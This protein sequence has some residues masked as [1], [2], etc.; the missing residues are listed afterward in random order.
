MKKS[1]NIRLALGCMALLVLT[2][3]ATGEEKESKPVN[4]IPFAELDAEALADWDLEEAPETVE[5]PETTLD[6]D[7]DAAVGDKVP[8]IMTE[9]QAKELVDVNYFCLTEL[10][11]YGQ[12][13]GEYLS[14]TEGGVAKVCDERF[15]TYGD[16]KTFLYKYYSSYVAAE[17]L[18]HAY[19]KEPMYYEE[20]D[21]FYMRLADTTPSYVSEEK[22]IPSFWTDYTITEIK[23]SGNGCEIRVVPVCEEELE[24]TTTYIMRATYLNGGWK[25]EDMGWFLRLEEL[26]VEEEEYT[27]HIRE[28][29]NKEIHPEKWHFADGW[30]LEIYKDGELFQIIEQT[31]E[32]SEPDIDRKIWYDDVNFD[33]KKD[34]LLFWFYTGA[35]SAQVYQ[36][37]LATEDGFE[38]C[39]S[40]DMSNPRIDADNRQII[41]S[42]R[43]GAGY[44]ELTYYQYEGNEFVLKKREEYEWDLDKKEYTVTTFTF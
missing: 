37:Y 27:F 26:T 2:G 20:N 6:V 38:L 35:Q 19:Q 10:F 40:F 43:G 28:I 8:V 16:L 5:A 13:E 1:R 17:M 25:L 18:N 41:G 32:L 23:Q 30:V 31:N 39:D 21:I 22:E 4:V 34:I 3:C 36:C 44:Y 14:W 11:V 7:W 29:Y 9:A 42:H 33:G 15:P 24:V 12:L